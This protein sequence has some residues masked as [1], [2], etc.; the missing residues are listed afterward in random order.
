VLYEP[1]VLSPQGYIFTNYG[2]SSYNALEV[3]ATKRFAHGSSI[4]ASYTLA[5]AKDMLSNNNSS[6]NV[7]NPF[8]L[9]EG[10]GPSDFDRRH[11]LVVSWL[12]AIP[13]HFTNRVA[14]SVLG[15]WTVTAIHTLE[16]GTPL[17]FYAG[18]DVAVDG[19]GGGQYAQLQPGATAGTIRIS[20]PN[21]PAMVNQFFNT[22]AF[23]PPASEPLG[24]YGDS[25]R[26]MISGPAYAN[27]DASVL[28]DFSIRKTTKLQLRVE[29]FNTFNQVNFANP[30]TNVSSGAFG[31]IQST[32]TQTGRQLQIAAKLNW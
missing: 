29:S 11:Q 25:R 7:P 5:S 2:T 12:Y 8:D 30:N 27:T 10:Y 19:T 16:S 18:Q 26:G 6:G 14:N 31:Q 23:L 28:K 1:G 9:K 24:S 20:H 13:V 15:G 22:Q 4:L 17:T 32:L 3:Q 21:R